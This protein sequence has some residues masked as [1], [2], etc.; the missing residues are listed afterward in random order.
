MAQQ[1]NTN[2]IFNVHKKK[3]TLAFI[4]NFDQANSKHAHSIA[5]TKPMKSHPNFA[6]YYAYVCYFVYLL[7]GPYIGLE[8]CEIIQ[9]IKR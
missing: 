3:F 8:F 1:T 2:T 7:F 4:A 5:Q 9:Q 6:F